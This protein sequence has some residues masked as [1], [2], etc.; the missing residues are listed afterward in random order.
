MSI[1][2]SLDNLGDW[3]ES[4][5]AHDCLHPNPRNWL[6]VLLVLLTTSF[7][8]RLLGIGLCTY[9]DEIYTPRP[10]SAY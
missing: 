8:S 7:I 6:R 2:N 3:T 1:E 10:P 9:L 5:L 4:P